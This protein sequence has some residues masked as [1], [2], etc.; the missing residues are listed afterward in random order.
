MRQELALPW[1]CVLLRK[2]A[3]SSAL[4]D[5][6]SWKKVARVKTMAVNLPNLSI[7]TVQ[8]LFTMGYFSNT[9]AASSIVAGDSFA[10]AADKG[11]VLYNTRVICPYPGN[12]EHCLFASDNLSENHP[13]HERPSYPVRTSGTRR[14]EKGARKRGDRRKS[15]PWRQEEQRRT[16]E[17]VPLPLESD[18]VSTSQEV[19]RCPRLEGRRTPL[20]RDNI[21]SQ[22]DRRSRRRRTDDPRH[23]RHH[24]PNFQSRGSLGQDSETHDYSINYQLQSQSPIPPPAFRLRRPGKWRSRGK[25]REEEEEEG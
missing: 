21:S 10:G 25:S 12:R 15:P 2:V 22:G 1:S 4:G 3:M 7:D 17:K 11:L 24:G 19:E 5:E 6:S 8:L 16:E 14:V 9:P 13:G 23:R 20:G 18:T